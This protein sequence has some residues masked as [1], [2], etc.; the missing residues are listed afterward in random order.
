MAA[1]FAVP[2]VNFYCT[3]ADRGGAI[4]VQGQLNLSVLIFHSRAGWGAL[5]VFDARSAVITDCMCPLTTALPLDVQFFTWAHNQL[6]L[7][8]HV[9]LKML[10]PNS[11]VL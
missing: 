10:R 11:V 1:P 6:L 7:Y 4:F 2:T 3:G 5:A 8:I 9:L